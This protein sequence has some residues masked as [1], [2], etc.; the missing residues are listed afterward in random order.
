MI[1]FRFLY[2]RYSIL[3]QGM[4][5][6]DPQQRRLLP[7]W[8]VQSGISLVN[9]LNR[10]VARRLRA[11]W[12]IDHWF[13]SLSFLFVKRK[14]FSHALSL[15]KNKKMFWVA[16]KKCSKIIRHI[17]GNFM[18]FQNWNTTNYHTKNKSAKLDYWEAILA[19]IMF[20]GPNLLPSPQCKS[21][22][23]CRFH[24]QASSSSKWTITSKRDSCTT[25]HDKSLGYLKQN[26]LAVPFPLLFSHWVL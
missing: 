24:P 14:W 15:K 12:P 21:T 8:S 17:K 6:N 10:S 2:K 25:A 20:T 26:L 1:S 9:S 18:L 5:Y 11:L 7:D 16:S 4:S 22:L 13:F 3:N 23:I 19:V